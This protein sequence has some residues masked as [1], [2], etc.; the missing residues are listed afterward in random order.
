M[1]KA[2]FSPPC[3]NV[4]ARNLYLHISLQAWFAGYPHD[5]IFLPLRS[6]SS[7]NTE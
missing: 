3:F 1:T 5:P 7:P 2:D 4:T 6:T